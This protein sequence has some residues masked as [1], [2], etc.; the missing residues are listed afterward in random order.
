MEDKLDIF[1]LAY[2]DFDLRVTN[3]I[4]KIVDGGE[5]KNEY[6]LP[7]LH[8]NVGRNISQLNVFFSELT[9][10][11]WILKNYELK[12]YVGI[13]HYRRYFTFFDDIPDMDEIF[14][15][16]DVILPYNYKSSTTIFRQYKSCHNI[17]D[18]ELAVNI[19]DKYYSEYS[20]C[21][22]DVLIGKELCINNI[23]IM[24]REDFIKYCDFVFGVLFRFISE[25]N[26]YSMKSV[27]DYVESNKD[28]YLKK[29]SPNN[30]IWYQ[31][32]IGGF[33]AE[34]LLSI[35]VKKHFKNPKYIKIE[36]TEKKYC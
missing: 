3:P 13:N 15:D 27:T 21:C 16:H 20:E 17:E 30:E 9:R 19:I 6:P 33:L 2:K 10:T 18:I 29:F 1:I 14:K 31:C 23:F 24:K 5:L 22:K 7:I 4:Y 28:K 8:D 11:Y 26:F 35:F 12:E 36:V 32:R 34:R 25:K